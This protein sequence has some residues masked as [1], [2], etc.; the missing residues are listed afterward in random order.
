VTP[1]KKVPGSNLTPEIASYTM[2]KSDM[3]L[4]TCEEVKIAVD[5]KYR[6]SIRNDSYT[7]PSQS[8]SPIVTC[9]A[10]GDLAGRATMSNPGRH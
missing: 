1:R 10:R 9:L 5:S 2:E 8:I 7:I 4:I 6:A 3:F